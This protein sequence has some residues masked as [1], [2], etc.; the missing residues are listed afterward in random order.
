[1]ANQR[2]ERAFYKKQGIP[3]PAIN[4]YFYN[5]ELVKVLQRNPGND[6]IYLYCFHDGKTKVTSYVEFQKQKRRA[7]NALACK[8][9][10]GR[11]KNS[12]EKY[13]AKEMI[14]RPH[15]AAIGNKR[16]PGI[17]GYYSE[18]DLYKIRDAISEIPF[19]APP[20]RSYPAKRTKVLTKQELRARIGDGRILYMQNDDGEFVPVWSE[21]V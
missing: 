13:I 12:W 3:A 2:R 18:D 11:S 10:I 17:R 21:S 5:K 4:I 16:G 14:P 7:W 19:G 8:K 20:K 6:T 15:Y 1:M 9:I